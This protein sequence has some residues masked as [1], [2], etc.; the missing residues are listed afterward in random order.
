[1]VIQTTRIIYMLLGFRWYGLEERFLSINSFIP[2]MAVKGKHPKKIDRSDPVSNRWNNKHTI[3]IQVRFWVCVFLTAGTLTVLYDA[4]VIAA[5]ILLRAF[6]HIS[7]RQNFPFW[8]ITYELD[9]IELIIII[10]VLQSTSFSLVS[11]NCRKE[12]FIIISSIMDLFWGQH[13][14]TCSY[15]MF[16]R[17]AYATNGLL[18]C[19]YALLDL[20]FSILL[21]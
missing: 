10:Y 4:I 9:E 5:Q 11:I 1:M 19:S 3:F 14:F 13:S 6:G 8:L 2:W 7:Q 16:V 17:H 12:D 21:K 18:F 15:N 20:P